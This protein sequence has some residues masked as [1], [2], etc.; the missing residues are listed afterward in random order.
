MAEGNVLR[1]PVFRVGKEH[2]PTELLYSYSRLT[3]K[4]CTLKPGQG[5]LKAGTPLEKDGDSNYMVANLAGGGDV[6]GLLRQTVE[7]GTDEEGPVFHGNIVT[8]GVVKQ[9]VVK[10]ACED[11]VPDLEAL[12]ART[13]ED[14]DNGDGVIYFGD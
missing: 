3:Q 7:T 13:D 14:A 9:S 2:I 4:G 8:A 5:L 6:R 1:A 10:A 11:A 12:G